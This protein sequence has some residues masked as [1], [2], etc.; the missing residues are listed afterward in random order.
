[1]EYFDSNLTKFG[2]TRNSISCDNDIILSL[3]TDH[4]DP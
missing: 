4:Q 2:L 1:M 3:P